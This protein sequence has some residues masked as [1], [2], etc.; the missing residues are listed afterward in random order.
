MFEIIESQT[1]VSWAFEGFSL[2]F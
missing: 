2:H 1:K